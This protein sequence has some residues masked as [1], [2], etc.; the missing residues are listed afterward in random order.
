MFKLRESFQ[1]V[2]FGGGIARTMTQSS[3]SERDRR[4]VIWIRGMA[5]RNPEALSA[6]YDE[7]SPLIFGLVYEILRD[8]KA[9][10]DAL[11]DIYQE[12]ERQAKAFDKQRQTPLDWLIALARDIAVRRLQAGRLLQRNAA[13]DYFK[14]ERLFA[15]MAMTGISD[16]QRSILEMVYLGG[17]TAP[18][19]ADIMN[20]SREYVEYQIVSA[21]KELRAACEDMNAVTESWSA[22]WKFRD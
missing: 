5:D 9:A 1:V 11:F 16:Q 17:L 10:E 13:T 19:V 8:Q 14:D 22:H 7:S 18:Q 6:L 21:M 15:S 3:D 20:V 4:W 12:A 2:Q